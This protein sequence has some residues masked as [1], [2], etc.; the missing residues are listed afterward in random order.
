MLHV[1]RIADLRAACDAARDAGATVRWVD[2]HAPDC[3]LDMESL[4]RQ[5]SERTRWVAVG[6]ASNAAGTINDV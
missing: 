6:C 3:T 1:D 5:L 4:R 2:V